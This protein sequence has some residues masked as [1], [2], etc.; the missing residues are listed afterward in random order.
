MGS[1]GTTTAGLSFGGAVDP[2]TTLNT[3]TE[4]WVSTTF[5]TKTVST[6]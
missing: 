4:E 3:A 6:D 1:S 2:A 5:S